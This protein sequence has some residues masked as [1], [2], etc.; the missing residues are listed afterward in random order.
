MK[1]KKIGLAVSL[2]SAACVTGL[3]YRAV[4]AAK[5]AGCRAI[6]PSGRVNCDALL[7]W[8]ASHPEI[9]EASGDKIDR[10]VE[11]TLRVRADR[12]IREH[13]LALLRGEYISTHQVEMDVAAM[14]QTAKLVLLAG[15]SSLAPQVVGVSVQEA[16][17]LLKEWLHSALDKL[18]KNPLG[19]TEPKSA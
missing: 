1:T 19:K 9:L 6:K 8:L 18:Q 17:T 4:Q 14:I 7:E 15:P 5:A 13:R 16:E 12:E 2:K 10:D 11:I 3:S